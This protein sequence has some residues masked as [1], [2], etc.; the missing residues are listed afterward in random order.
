MTPFTM[1]LPPW[2]A[3]CPVIDGLA[4]FVADRGPVW[5]WES[6]EVI[7]AGFFENKGLYYL[8]CDHLG[9]AAPRG[10]RA[11][12][13]L[14]SDNIDS[15]RLVVA[16]HGDDAYARRLLRN[17]DHPDLV[18]LSSETED[19]RRRPQPLFLPA[20]E[21][22]LLK[23]VG[24]LFDSSTLVPRPTGEAKAVTS[25]SLLD[26]IEVAF[27]VDGDSALPLLLPRQKVFGGRQLAAT[28]LVSYRGRPLAVA[29]EGSEAAVKRLGRQLSRQAEHVWI[30]EPVGARGESMLVRLEAKPDDRFGDIPL[31]RCVRPILGV[32]Y[33]EEVG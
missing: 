33:A 6:E 10:S 26:E 25:S 1:A 15:N 27:N 29:T 11:I 20:S 18:V 5:G 22:R 23:V 14:D 3:N 19:P 13:D 4:A 16:L 17:E 32:L 8:N 12:V 31:A 21:V 9:F 2:K 7:P 24:V 30:L 28:E